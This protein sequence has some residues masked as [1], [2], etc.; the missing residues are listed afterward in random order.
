L[1]S[2]EDILSSRGRVRILKLLL[3][4]E[5]LN[6]SAIMRKCALNYSAVVYHL[7]KLIEAGLVREKRFGKIRIFKINKNNPTNI[8]LGRVFESLNQ[9]SSDNKY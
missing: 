4:Q 9:T 6:I 8:L 5:E 3:E 1:V 2:I 7:E